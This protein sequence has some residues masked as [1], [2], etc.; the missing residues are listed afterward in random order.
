MENENMEKERFIEY[1]N[2]YLQRADVE[3]LKT[4]FVFSKKLVG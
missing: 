3:Q 4:L 1:I 2:Y